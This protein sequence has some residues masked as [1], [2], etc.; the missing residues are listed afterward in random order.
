[1]IFIGFA[2]WSIFEQK[3]KTELCHSGYFLLPNFVNSIVNGFFFYVGC[4]VMRTIKD[5]NRH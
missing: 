3:N 4:K 5:F 2:I 1:M